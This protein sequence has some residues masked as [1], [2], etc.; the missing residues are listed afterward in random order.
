MILTQEQASSVSPVTCQP[1]IQSGRERGR[2]V[3]EE[4]RKGWVVELH[5]APYSEGQGEKDYNEVYLYSTMS[6][7][8]IVSE[9]HVAQG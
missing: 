2:W 1:A 5:H 4:M 3:E 8:V 7:H 6:I 9:G